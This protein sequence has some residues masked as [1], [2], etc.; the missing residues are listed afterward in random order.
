MLSTSRL[1]LYLCYLV[2][3]AKAGYRENIFD[4]M[5]IWMPWF[6]Y[7]F[8]NNPSFWYR[9]P[10]SYIEQQQ[11]TLPLQA[12]NFYTEFPPNQ[13]CRIHVLWPQI[14]GRNVK[15]HFSSW[16]GA[17][18]AR[19]K[20]SRRKQMSHMANDSWLRNAKIY[21]S[22]IAIWHWKM[23]F[24]IFD[25]IGPC[26]KYI[27]VRYLALASGAGHCSSHQNPSHQNQTPETK[28]RRSFYQ[29]EF[30][31]E[32]KLLAERCSSPLPWIRLIILPPGFNAVHYKSSHVH[33][34]IH[35]Y[36]FI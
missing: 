31:D 9:V 2:A 27:E 23:Y 33:W 10:S 29:L 7:R 30:D 11:F 8:K 14:L 1:S 25:R 6:Q 3:P 19:D 18:L 5:P 26:Y 12:Q 24:S 32:R 20:L 13:V 16:S 35:K 22:D 34:Q 28:Q 4:K 15:F 36:L 17:T 21:L